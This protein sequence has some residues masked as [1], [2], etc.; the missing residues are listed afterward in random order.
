MRPGERARRGPR[1]FTYVGL[2]VLLV[3]MG[4][5]L[6]AAGEV[7]ATAARREREVQ[8]LWVGHQYQA[9]IQRFVAQRRAY[10]RTLEELLGAEPDAPLQVRYLRSLYRDPM[11]SAV[12]WV[13]LPAP[14]GGIKGVASR[15]GRAPLKTARFE[16]AD[17]DF[18]D[19]TTYGDWR[20]TYPPGAPPKPSPGQ[21]TQPAGPPLPQRPSSHPPRSP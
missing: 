9:A 15:S 19:A 21:A 7:V 16:D 13:L 10:P 11:T 8:L 12:D 14:G 4:L 17:R 5:L 3:L 1:G 18:V 6:S 2:L 20:F